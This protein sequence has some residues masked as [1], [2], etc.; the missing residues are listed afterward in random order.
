MRHGTR[1]FVGLALAVMAITPAMA[2]G[3]SKE[4]HGGPSRL[5]TDAEREQALKQGGDTFGSALPIT[6]V[7]F[8]DSGT[9]L[10]Y[11][12]DYDAVCL[13][14]VDGSAPDVVY[15]F[16]APATGTYDF[17]LCGSDFDTVLFIHE[18]HSSLV[19][20][21]DDWMYAAPVEDP[22]L[23][24]SRIT[25]FPA[26]AGEI[27]Y[28]VVDG[29]QDEA[30]AYELSV[31]SS[32]PCPLEPAG[33]AVAEGEPSLG[34][35]PDTYNCGCSCAGEMVFQEVVGNQDG[36]AAVM[37]EHGWRSDSSRDADWF[38][39][40]AGSTG[41]VHLEFEA[42]LKSVVWVL[43]GVDCLQSEA[44]DYI[45]AACTP[46]SADVALAPGTVFYVAVSVHQTILPPYGVLPETRAALLSA[47]G[48]A[49]GVP[50][51]V[52][53]WGEVKSIYR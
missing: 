21:N 49:T 11:V 31:Q 41:N 29:Y 33:Y 36:A 50:V 38:Q 15:V 48:L 6:S 16:T 46:L 32:T 10:G 34:A 1:W 27:Y 12:D 23:L 17:S 18:V 20:C 14:S 24:D 13:E 22:C 39:F 5:A 25:D 37:L 35:A 26:Q 42:E 40:T 51:E 43:H 2:L 44:D 3:T 4:V 9:T 19:A 8:S 52:T 47:A 7:P 53:S 45:V 28:L 30:G